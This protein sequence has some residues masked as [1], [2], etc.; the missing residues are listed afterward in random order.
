MAIILGEGTGKSTQ[1]SFRRTEGGNSG[2][3][4]RESSEGL[5]TSQDDPGMTKTVPITKEGNGKEVCRLTDE[6]NK[7]RSQ[8]NDKLGGARTSGFR[9]DSG[10][11][12]PRLRTGI[13]MIIKPMSQSVGQT[14]TFGTDSRGSDN[15]CSG[16]T[17][18]GSLQAGRRLNLKPYRG[19]TRCTEF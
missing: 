16:C 7:W 6:V 3:V 5:R 19:K 1:G 12:S 13:R 9:R 11:T 2:E 18:K 14:C 15:V 17:G 4:S 8:D 10:N